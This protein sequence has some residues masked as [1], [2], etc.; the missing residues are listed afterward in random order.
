MLFVVFGEGLWR[1]HLYY[2]GIIKMEVEVVG[3]DRGSS[4]ARRIVVT[5]RY[6][7]IVHRC[8]A[9]D[10]PVFSCMVETSLILSL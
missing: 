6:N 2:L 9:V 5:I 8:T 7:C 1:T 4:D 10:L 3:L